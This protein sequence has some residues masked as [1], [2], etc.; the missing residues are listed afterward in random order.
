M[1]A[2]SSLI[3]PEKINSINNKLNLYLN[4]YVKEFNK[5]ITKISCIE[6]YVS[7]IYPLVPPIII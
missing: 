5:F 3:I 4:K 1:P 7:I 2:L 6:I